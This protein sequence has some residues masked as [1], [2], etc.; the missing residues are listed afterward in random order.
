MLC[1]LES[2]CVCNY[3]CLVMSLFSHITVLFNISKDHRTVWGLKFNT[4]SASKCLD[5]CYLN[6][7]LDCV[8][9][10]AAINAFNA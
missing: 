8:C 4:Y 5:I 9:L 3:F 10:E 6:F 2:V 7:K 1:Y